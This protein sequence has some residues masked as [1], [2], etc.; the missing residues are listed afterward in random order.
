MGTGSQYAA[1]D[2]DA[3]FVWDFQGGGPSTPSRGTSY[4]LLAVRYGADM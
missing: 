1:Q 2:A 4:S 3:A